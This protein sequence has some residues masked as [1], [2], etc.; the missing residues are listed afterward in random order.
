MFEAAAA[1]L[2]DY[3]GGRLVSASVSR[4][5]VVE[6][7]TASLAL[8]VAAH[9]LEQYDLARSLV[10]AALARDNLITAEGGEPLFWLLATAAYGV[11][12]SGE[13]TTARV[14]A[15]GRTTE[16]RFDQGVAMVDVPHPSGSF[17]V[18]VTTTGDA[19]ALV[20][21]EAVYVEPFTARTDG[22]VDLALE[23]DPGANDGVSALELVVRARRELRTPVVL[24]ELPAGIEVDDGRLL[25]QLASAS[26]V[27]RVEPRRPGVVRLILGA[28]PAGTEIRIPLSLRWSLYGR[29][30]GLAAVGFDAEDPDHRTVTAP[31]TI[32]RPAGN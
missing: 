12:G 20:R 26:G 6:E 30:Q 18:D 10:R 1:H 4:E 17:D 24:I 16:A 25:A 23:G 32:D 5:D 7:I 28:M 9:Q 3:A 13:P 2:E 11:L 31:I 14:T 21:A 22:P 8:A 29:I 27:L 19:I 15:G